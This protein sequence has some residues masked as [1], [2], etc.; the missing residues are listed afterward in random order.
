[1][2]TKSCGSCHEVTELVASDPAELKTALDQGPGYEAHADLDVPDWNE[3]F[4]QGE[5]V[6]LLNF[7]IAPDGQRLFRIDCAACHGQS[8]TF[9]GEEDELRQVIAEGGLHL[10]MPSWQERLTDGEIDRL[11]LYVYDP[12]SAPSVVPLFVEYCSEC[13]GDRVPEAASFQ[14]AREIIAT[15]GSHETMP[16][17]GEILTDEQMDALVEYTLAAARGAPL[18]LG[19]QLYAENCVSCHGD[20]GE[21]G[22]NP[23]RDGDIIAPISTAEYLQT[24]DDATLY[25]IIATGHTILGPEYFSGLRSSL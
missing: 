5:R 3:E 15:G 19:Q 2:F 12:A 6:A 13:H 8:L 22:A 24:R 18:E 20:F 1:M 10:E 11:A 7:L 4:E 23:A 9:D 21:G 14:D 25:S 17:W 16:V